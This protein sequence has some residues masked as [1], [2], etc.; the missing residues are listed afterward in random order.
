VLFPVDADGWVFSVGSITYAGALAWNGCDN[1]L[2]RLTAN[3]LRAFAS[4][5]PVLG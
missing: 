2:S 3:V 1:D 5:K 4:R